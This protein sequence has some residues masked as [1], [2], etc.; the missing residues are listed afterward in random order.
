MKKLKQIVSY[1]LITSLLCSVSLIVNAK[2][3]YGRVVNVADGDTVTILDSSKQQHRIRLLHI[4]APERGQAFGRV[5]QNAL[6]K[7]INKRQVQ[8]KYKEKDRYG[9]I[10]GEI[11]LNGENINLWLVQNGYAWPYF[12]Y[13]PP[14]YYLDAYRVA[15]LYKNGLWQDPNPIEPETFRHK[16]KQK[17]SKND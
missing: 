9:R 6:A 1:G 11:I 2:T 8:V 14:A 10:L 17:R 13:N 12:R 16:S 7:R 5:A 3:L 15:K 4:D